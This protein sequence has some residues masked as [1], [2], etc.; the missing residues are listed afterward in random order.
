[1]GIT[2]KEDSISGKSFGDQ[3]LNIEDGDLKE[4]AKLGEYR[5]FYCENYINWEAYSILSEEQKKNV[6]WVI[7]PIEM[8]QEIE[9]SFINRFPYENND[10]LVIFDYLQNKH[11]LILNKNNNMIYSGIVKREIPSNIL[12]IKNTCRFDTDNLFS[13]LDNNLN[14][15][16]YNL[17]N[18]LSFISYETIFSFFSMLNASSIITKFLS[19]IILCNKKMNSFLV[20]E[21][22]EYLKVNFLKYKNTSFSLEM[23]KSMLIFDFQKKSVFINYYLNKI[24]EKNFDAYII[25][26]FLECSDLNS[27]VIEFPT[28]CSKQNIQ[29]TTYYL[30]LQY[31]LKNKR[32]NNIKINNKNSENHVVKN[33]IDNRISY[34]YISKDTSYKKFFENNYYI[35]PGL[36]ITSNN[37]FNNIGEYDKKFNDKYYELEIRTPIKHCE[38]NYHPTFS[39]TEYNI[40][41]YSLYNE[42]NIIF[43]SDSV[44][45]CLYT[46]ENKIIFEFVYI[47]FWDPILYMTKETK[48]KFCMIE[49][50]LKYLADEQRKKILFARVKNKESK[51]IG[52]LQNLRELLIFDDSEPKTDIKNVA[53]YF[54]GF[55]KLECLSIIGNNLLNKDCIKLSEGLKNLKRLKILNL[56]YDSLIDCNIANLTFSDDNK[57]EVLNLKANSITDSGMKIFKT[58]IKKLINLK[59]INF[60]DNQFYDQGFKYL[61]ESLEKISTINSLILQN[62]GIS[63]IGIK[64]FAEY[65]DILPNFLENLETLDLT[66]NAF[67]DDCFYE[68]VKIFKNLKNLKKYSIGQTQ[69][70]NYSILKIFLSLKKNNNKWYFEKK[71]GWFKISEKNYIE[72]KKFNENI[73]NNENILYFHRISKIWFKR[74]WKKLQNKLCFD[75]SEAN[76][77]DDNT[78]QLSTLLPMFPNLKYLNLSYSKISPNGFMILINFMKNLYNLS[79]IHFS[80]SNISDESLSIICKIFEN[81]KRISILNFSFNNITDTG[82]AVLCRELIANKIKIKEINL[83]GNEI[84]DAGFK[85]FHS[86]VNGKGFRTL[87]KI[88]FGKNSIGDDT[89][90]LFLSLI[91]SFSNLMEINFSDNNITDEGVIPFG[92]VF[93]D[94]I[95]NVQFVDISGNKISEAL[96]EFFM[97]ISLPLNIKY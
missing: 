8:S 69:L 96:K 11:M 76:L 77:T 89:M 2:Q 1:M 21:Y 30:C 56:S 40:Q 57:I 46:N 91:K 71:G 50:G 60:H 32:I 66:S 33:P 22:K 19:T 86:S 35:A 73:K 82:F 41:K 27:V 43:P 62:C 34:L 44:F 23:L 83:Y 13:Y 94:L 24:N 14:Q 92:S 52:G 38:I 54:N 74:N 59:E 39:N 5:W 55:R 9:R 37:K 31:I 93:N 16:Q 63:N 97:E 12:H 90:I 79:E 78:L 7:F 81:C 3:L 88:N 47:S 36:V 4:S 28:K 87:Q 49:E 17:V 61:L 48:K 10:K 67:G 95:D 80:S 26:M 64:H 70:S 20:N 45:K 51:F 75:F 72:S 25:K 68:L 65:F 42:E 53:V 18:N 6:L 58:E 84:K 15:Y 29:Y 85:I